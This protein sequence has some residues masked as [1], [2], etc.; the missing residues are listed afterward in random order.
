M[1]GSLVTQAVP[2]LGFDDDVVAMS[3]AAAGVKHGAVT[4][5]TEPGMTMVGPCATGDVLGVVLYA[6]QERP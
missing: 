3:S 4:V 2:D 5:A 1:L 6:Y